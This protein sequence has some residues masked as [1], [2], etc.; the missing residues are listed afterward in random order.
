LPTTAPS[1]AA[2]D[3]PV[4][5]VRRRIRCT[6]DPTGDILHIKSLVLIAVSSFGSTG[7][8]AGDGAPA[9][10][11]YQRD[12]RPL[13][14]DRCYDCHGP[15]AARRKAD[16]RLDVEA[17]V[18]AERQGSRAV[19]PGDPAGSA[20]V[21]RIG[22]QDARK[23]MPPAASG[24]SLSAAEAALLERW[25]AE[26]AKWERHWAFVPPARPVP[27]ATRLE[28]WARNPID[29]FVLKRLEDEGLRPSP[30]APPETLI[31]RASL[32]LTGLAPAP[33][34][35]DAFLAD[36]AP[37]AYER[38]LDQLLASPRHGEHLA[39]RWLDAARYAD[40]SGYQSDGPR[41]MWR[42]RD[43][44]IAAYNQ[45]LPFDRFTIEQLA[46]DLLPE[47]TLEQRIA[48]GFHRNHR[49]N[50]EGGVIPEEYAVEYV[51]DRVETTAM[52]WLGL[53]LGC[54]RCH[55]HKY[56]PFTQKDFYRLFAFF[57]NIPERGKAVKLGNSPP[58]LKTPTREDEAKLEAL[59]R[60]LA[61]ARTA[62]AALEPETARLQAE[63]ERTLGPDARCVSPPARG[64]LHRYAFEGEGLDPRAAG[65]LDAG[66]VANFGFLDKFSLAARVRPR[67]EEG[68][69][70]LARKSTNP[71]T[72]EGYSLVLARGKLQVNL[73]KRPLDDAIRVETEEGFP[74][75]QSTH[76]LV[77]YDGSRAASGVQV[78]VD[79]RP[80]RLRV[81]VDDLNQSFASKEPL[82]IG[83]AGLPGA[84]FAGA[85]TEVRVYGRALSP[86]EAEVL[87]LR[88]PLAAAAVAA[89][90]RTAAQ[91]RALRAVFLETAAPER[92]RKAH[93]AVLAIAETREKLVEGFPTTMVLAEMAA[94]R[95]T[96]VLTRGAYDRPGERVE[97][98]VPAALPALP[99][100]APRNRLGLALWLVD[101]KNPL[102]ARVAVNRLWQMLF[103]IGLVKTVEDFGS[104]GEPP[105]HP[106]LL[107]WLAVELVE[108]GWD[109]KALLRLIL[110]S[111]AYRQSSRATPEILRRDPENRLLARGPRFRLAAGTIRD[112]A[113]LA[114]GLLVEKLGGPSVRP[115]QPPGLWKEL[116]GSQDYE[117]DHG[118]GLYRRSLY[119]YW[120]RT[121]AP[122]GMVTFDASPRE[123][124]CVREP[125]TNTP[126]QALTLLNEVTFVEAARRLAQRAMVE[127]GDGP[128]ARLERLFR[129]VLA[130]GPRPE[131]RDILLQGLA[132]H[133][134]AYRADRK[135]AADLLAAG[136]SP[137]DA[138]LDPAELAAYT[139]VAS[140]VLNLDETVTKE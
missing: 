121:A 115:Y 20:L 135:A 124:A 23:R 11:D 104:Q 102:V 123:T 8:A 45:N 87:A 21:R 71:A 116:T 66:Q 44:V 137:R 14:A 94:P 63:W 129:L 105:S 133:L 80:A 85:I 131:E 86:G 1:G 28:G 74:A 83:S 91:A 77:T 5:S 50:G 68:G 69:T 90:E 140:I 67:G 96:F 19:V 57:N 43:W 24:K 64:L 38:V 132:H 99:G 41:T 36:R 76:V 114:S 42:W 10:V 62:A 138:A 3:P 59:D 81:L 22:H 125:R 37:G 117:Q 98:G 106:E 29:A 52:V 73:I 15:D 7:R 72:E 58:Y 60:E 79:G 112:Q 89:A 108:S 130:R 46:G 126:L 16:L 93:E 51:A 75:G 17:S 25:I 9:P 49:G 27:P 95:P 88:D 30:E 39:A 128:A 6:V 84:Q 70:I 82:R 12:V 4:P 54:A 134:D 97:A 2:A 127:G 53:T 18:L 101:R 113:L 31:R 33:A 119:T 40:T 32:D 100:G 13:L 78:Y 107:D 118:E 55:D 48:T 110:A 120:K 92:V 26:G 61:A 56:D 103:G 109:Q 34:E 47:A 136:E 139:A 111:A 35:V 122:P 65:F